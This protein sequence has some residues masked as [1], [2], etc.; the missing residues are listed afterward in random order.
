M[1]CIKKRIL[2]LHHFTKFAMRKYLLLI[3]AMFF[4]T[5]ALFAQVVGGETGL[6]TWE[7]NLNTGTLTISGE[8]AMPNYAEG[9]G[10]N[11]A[12]WFE[13]WESI[14]T[15]VMETGVTSIGDFAFGTGYPGYYYHNLSS[16]TIPNS[17]T[18][19][20][21]FAFFE[22]HITSIS[23][24]NSVT[25]IGTFAFSGSSLTS[26]NLPNSVITIGNG[27]FSQCLSSITLS[28][29]LTTIGHGA[30][31][32]SGIT[33]INIPNSVTSIGSLAFALCGALHRAKSLKLHISSLSIQ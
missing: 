31:W 2:S 9:I 32:G 33:S 26:I 25:T 16:V 10:I 3:A 1:E 22:C 29:N 7:L 24:P 14:H 23:L 6:L 28:N 20:G 8:G 18:T 13:H 30:F 4:S 17:V 27:A 15:V 11:A 12:P 21:E 19:I 5:V